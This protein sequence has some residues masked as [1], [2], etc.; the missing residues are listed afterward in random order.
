MANRNSQLI[1]YR[2]YGANSIEN[3]SASVSAVWLRLFDGDARK[4]PRMWNE[5]LVTSWYRA[6]GDDESPRKRVPLNAVSDLG[7][8]SGRWQWRVYV[9]Q[10]RCR[11]LAAPE[12][13]VEF[14]RGRV[15]SLTSSFS[16]PRSAVTAI[17]CA[18][19]FSMRWLSRSQTRTSHPSGSRRWT[20]SDRWPSRPW[21]VEP[22]KTVGARPRPVE[23]PSQ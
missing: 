3:A 15:F 14:I 18:P 16:S 5:L 2:L 12:S 20:A 7:I 13:R 11:P 10:K 23:G 4:V 9:G 6:G 17:R 1:S 21:L 19:G 8:N 22:Q